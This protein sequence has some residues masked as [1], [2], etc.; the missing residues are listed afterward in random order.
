MVRKAQITVIPNKVRLYKQTRSPY[1]FADIL[2]ADG[3]RRRL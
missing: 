1:F 3:S 2:L